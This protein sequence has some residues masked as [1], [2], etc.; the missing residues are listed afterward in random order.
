MKIDKS[1]LVPSQDAGPDRE[2]VIRNCD[3]GLC[4]NGTF[5]FLIGV[6]VT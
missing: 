4:G 5:Y 3:E 2:G 1:D 6:L